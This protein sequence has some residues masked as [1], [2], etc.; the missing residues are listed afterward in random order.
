MS[1]ALIKQYY[2]KGIYTETDL[3]MFV[4]AGYITETE[5]NELKKALM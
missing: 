4:K 2:R 3:D 5:A 1:K